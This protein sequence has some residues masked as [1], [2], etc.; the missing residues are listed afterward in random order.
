MTDAAVTASMSLVFTGMA[1]DND[2]IKTKAHK[3]CL[4]CNVKSTTREKYDSRGMV[5][6]DML[7][8]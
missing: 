7:H 8:A 2:A 5:T 6:K 4:L 1:H 3:L